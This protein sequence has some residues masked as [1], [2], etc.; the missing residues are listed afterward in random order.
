MTTITVAPD[1]FYFVWQID[2]WLSNHIET[3][4]T[5]P[6]H[7]LIF[8]RQ[9]QPLSAEMQA[10]QRKYSSV[11][12]VNFFYY[13]DK[14]G[15]VLDKI[16][17]VDYI[18]LLRPF[19][20]REHFKKYKHLEKDSIWY[21]DS[22][23]LYTK[24]LDFTPYLSDDI[25]YLSDTIS[26]VGYSYLRSKEKDVLLSKLEKFKA[27][28]VI[29]YLTRT[30]GLSENILEQ[31]EQGSGGAQYLLK[32]IDYTF[33]DNVYNDSVTIRRY[34]SF[35]NK[36]FFESEE[37]GFQ[38]WTADM[39]AVLWNLWKQNKITKCPKDFDFC[40]ATDP[41]KAIDSHYIYHNAGATGT[42]NIFYKGKYANNVNCPQ[43]DID[44][45]K[46][47]SDKYASYFYVQHLL[48]LKN[49]ICK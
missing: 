21:V 43:A 37:K 46:S 28:N 36:R 10:L 49:P 20:L 7:I 30:L 47:I 44:Y 13:Q 12:F 26:Y 32:N 42:P 14:D 24:Y 27:S 40:W 41:Y 4:Y 5:N 9:D 1:E 38:S 19:C 11:S 17:E 16:R 18:P 25:C 31:N 3:G 45:L 2:L 39:W 48:K 35:I 22:D 6:I 33:W 23:I 29:D 34:L 8:R 15:S